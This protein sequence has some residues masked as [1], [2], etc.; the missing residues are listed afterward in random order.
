MVSQ[1]FPNGFQRVPV[2][3]HIFA[4]QLPTFLRRD[5]LRF[6]QREML[7]LWPRYAAMK[8]G[9]LT[10]FGPM[11]LMDLTIQECEWRERQTE[12]G[13]PYSQHIFPMK[14]AW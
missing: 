14:Y 9:D 1:W 4:G 5:T 12:L 10:R 2:F 7:S 6:L 8:R 13:Y 11:P 3:F